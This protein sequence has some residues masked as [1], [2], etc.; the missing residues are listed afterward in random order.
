[1]NLHDGLCAEGFGLLVS[2]SVC[3]DC[4]YSKCPDPSSFG[5][6]ARELE[7]IWYDFMC[8][9]VFFSPARSGKVTAIQIQPGFTIL[10]VCEDSIPPWNNFRLGG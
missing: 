6:G 1:M 8:R 2:P 7:G 10:G 3:F 4:I 5:V 9:H